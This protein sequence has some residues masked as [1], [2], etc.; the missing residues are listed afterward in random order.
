MSNDKPGL[1]SYLDNQGKINVLQQIH[2]FCM[3]YD[4]VPGH[5]AHQWSQTLDALMAVIKSIDE[6]EKAYSKSQNRP[7]HVILPP[8]PPREYRE[9]GGKVRV[10]KS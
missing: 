3:E 9:E 6:D 2:T 7:D 4:R 10:P 1:P 8:A 5:M